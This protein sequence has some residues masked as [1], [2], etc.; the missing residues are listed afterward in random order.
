MS[1]V[2]PHC[3]LRHEPGACALSDAAGGYRPLVVGTKRTARRSPTD[4]RVLCASCRQGGSTPYLTHAA[5]ARAAIRDSAK[6]CQA[7]TYTWGR[8]CGAR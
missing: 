2:C 6:P 8:G 3:G 4:Y 1:P 7:G 5:A